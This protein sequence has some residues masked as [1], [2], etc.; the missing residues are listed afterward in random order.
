MAETYLKSEFTSL[1]G[2]NVD[3]GVLRATIEKNGIIVVALADGPTA[4]RWIDEVADPTYEITFVSTLPA[5]QVTE[6]DIL[7]AAH[8]GPSDVSQ[9]VRVFFE[10]TPPLVTDDSDRLFEIG[11][12]WHDS[13]TDHAYILT[14]AT[15]GAAA[16]LWTSGWGLSRPDDSPKLRSSLQ[17]AGET[18]PT[19]NQVIITDGVGD[20]DLADYGGT[21]DRGYFE[22]FGAVTSATIPTLR[23]DENPTLLAGRYLLEW[24]CTVDGS[25]TATV[26]KATFKF[27]GSDIDS[28]TTDAAMKFSG[29][30]ER[31]V[32]AGAKSM[33]LEIDKDSG[34]GSAE[35]S[36]SAMRYTWIAAT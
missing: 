30:V 3:A 14:D 6:L 35:M 11:D 8:A 33:Q 17:T 13:S 19:I 21:Q 25:S 7:I 5:P 16:W 15:V 4:L 2:A 1:G 9:A 20:W 36:Q 32:T 28:I 24:M 31:V 34:G 22:E 18:A 23:M 27:A 29:F 12:L 26:S 10:S